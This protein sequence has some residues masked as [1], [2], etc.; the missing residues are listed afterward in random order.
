MSMCGGLA[1]LVPAFRAREGRGWRA[2]HAS[3]G[4]RAGLG[5]DLRRC[6]FTPKAA[7]PASWLLRAESRSAEGP[8]EGSRDCC[9]FVEAAARARMGHVAARARAQEIRVPGSAL[10][11]S[12][13][14]AR[15]FA[16][17]GARRRS[18][19]H[20]RSESLAQTLASRTA[21]ASCSSNKTSAAGC[22]RPIATG[23]TASSANLA[24]RTSDCP[25]PRLARRPDGRLGSAFECP[26]SRSC[27]TCATRPRR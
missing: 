16:G 7:M 14:S 5:E 26:S 10:S 27:S 21:P 9:V 17:G 11:A 13:A 22:C 15:S 23:S 18:C 4:S 1:V 8:T 2:R 24:S 6:R 25:R 12:R 20:D 19:K 3:R